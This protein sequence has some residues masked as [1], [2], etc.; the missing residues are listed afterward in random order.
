MRK[1]IKRYIAGGTFSVRGAHGILLH[2]P[3]ITKTEESDNTP[4]PQNYSLPKSFYQ[5]YPNWDSLKLKLGLS[6]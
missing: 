3:I 2:P 6:R 5:R 1:Q 4:T